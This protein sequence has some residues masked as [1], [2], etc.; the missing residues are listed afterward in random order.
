M[1]PHSLH[2]VVTTLHFSNDLV[3]LVAVERSAISD[4]SSRLC[5]KRRVVENDLAFFSGLKFLHALPILDDGEHFAIFRS[6][7]QVAFEYR[8]RK[9]LIRGVR[10]LLCSAFP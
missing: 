6:R 4:L 8:F 10:S 1:C 7:L 3:Q 5:I 2:R 9:L